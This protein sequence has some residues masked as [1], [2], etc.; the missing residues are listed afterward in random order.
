MVLRKRES[1]MFRA[2]SFALV[3]GIIYSSVLSSWECNRGPHGRVRVDG[4]LKLSYPARTYAAYCDGQ[5]A[6]YPEWP[7]H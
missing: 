6:G 5:D 2:T 4:T 3:R 7:P 1:E